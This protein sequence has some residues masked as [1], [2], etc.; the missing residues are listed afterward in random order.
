[1]WKHLSNAFLYTVRIDH[2]SWS[3]TDGHLGCVHPWRLRIALCARGARRRLLSGIT[4]LGAGGGGRAGKRGLTFL[5]LLLLLFP[6][7]RD[8]R[9][10]LYPTSS[11]S[12]EKWRQ[13]LNTNN[14]AAAGG[15]RRKWLDP[16]LLKRKKA[17]DLASDATPVATLTAES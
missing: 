13:M 16:P 14:T 9:V 4:G 3:S 1:M 2:T 17:E 10:C 8:T 11:D 7:L 5:L 12:G 15:R 6:K